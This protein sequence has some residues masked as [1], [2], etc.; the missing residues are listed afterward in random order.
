M[1]EWF[2][3]PVLVTAA[4]LI[5]YKTLSNWTYDKKDLYEN[6]WL[7]PIGKKRKVIYHH[8]DHYPHLLVGGAT[9]MGKTIF[10]KSIFS[11]LILGNPDR[12]KIIILDLKGGLE[13]YKYRNLPQVKTV[14]TSLID[15]CKVLNHVYKLIKLE[16]ERYLKNNWTNVAETPIKE[17]TFIIVDESAEL[18]P[19]LVPKE[20][21]KHAE[22]AQIYLSE[23]ARIGGGLGFRL[24][25]ATQYPSKESVS[26]SIKMNMMARVA[27]R[28]PDMVG[29]RVILDEKGAEE[30]EPIPGRAI[31]KLAQSHEIQC[32]YINDIQIGGFLHELQQ[33][34]KDSDDN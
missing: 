5:P 14:A 28:M 15:S 24:I 20:F 13:F 1:L 9:R 2:I 6:S 31:Y 27:F 30:L 7:V 26:M 8:F 22:L 21:K 34:R 4:A 32:P 12:V 29:S 11:S 23:I 18:S 25:L 33:A 16:E 10:L 17:R 3:P 19:K